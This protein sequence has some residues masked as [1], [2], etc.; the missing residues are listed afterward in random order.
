M[1]T[2]A[3]GGASAVGE[4]EMEDH[5]EMEQDSRSNVA[6][7]AA[8]GTFIAGTA[9][10]TVTEARH[11]TKRHRADEN[12]SED[13]LHR[14][15][16]DYGLVC[17]ERAKNLVWCFFQKFGSKKLKGAEDN[18]KLAQ[19]ALCTICLT[20]KARRAYCT[21]RLG[22]D[23][24]P[25]SMMD[26]LRIHHRDEFDAVAVANSKGLTLAAFKAQQKEPRVRALLGNSSP[27]ETAEQSH[28]TP[29]ATPNAGNGAGAARHEASMLRHCALQTLLIT[30]A[31]YT[32]AVNLEDNP[33]AWWKQHGHLFPTLSRLARRY[34][35][36]PATSCPVERLFSVAGQVDSSRRANLS[37]DNLTLLVFMHEALPLLRRIRALKIV[38]EAV[39]TLGVF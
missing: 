17:P 39:G 30:H 8:R 37:S 3:R 27:G 1:N 9:A 7:L 38:Q 15:I 4:E 18:L 29:N 34:L 16:Q 31:S 5:V 26:H 21:V 6:M 14:R 28:T 13:F 25:S 22:K 32:N 23:N 33:L 19:Q 10:V 36:T 20:D 35:A 24:S 12:V 2:D 11:S